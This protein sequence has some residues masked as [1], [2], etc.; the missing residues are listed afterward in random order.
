MVRGVQL[1]LLAVW[2]AQ[3]AVDAQNIPPLVNCG[4]LFAE[5]CTV[6]DQGR[7]AAWCNGDCMWDVNS[8]VPKSMHPIQAFLAGLNIGKM[9]YGGAPI[10]GMLLISGVF[11]AIYK[12]KV[13][14]EIPH[15]LIKQGLLNVGQ[16]T[17]RE[18]GLF[19][20]FKSPSTCLT[21]A[22]CMPAVAAKNYEIG[23]VLGFWPSC[24]A[25]A[26]LLYS[27]L[28][29]LSALL[30]TIL[31]MKLQT[32]LDFEPEPAKDCLL[33]L[34]CGPCEVGRQSLEVDEAVKVRVQFFKVEQTWLPERVQD[35]MDGNAGGFFC[36]G[37]RKNCS[38]SS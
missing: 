19:D 16:L 22:F 12:R 9:L 24:I 31:G 26:L 20:C 7:G 10:L 23:G 15:G 11:A 33:H 28:C 25:H 38:F 2:A 14:D 36:M 1:L 37:F 13:V 6:C 32:N 21:T 34:F 3:A 8:C 35:A 27:P 30:R 29:F 4:G 5:T 17:P 18:R